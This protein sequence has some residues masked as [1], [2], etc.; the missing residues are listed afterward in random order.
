MQGKPGAVTLSREVFYLFTSLPE[1]PDEPGGPLCLHLVSL[2]HLKMWN[3]LEMQADPVR[4]LQ[5][6]KKSTVF[7]TEHNS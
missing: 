6:T 1:T 2:F 4:L 5:V 7:K 3:E